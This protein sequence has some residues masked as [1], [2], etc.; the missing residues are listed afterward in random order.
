MLNMLKNH[1]IIVSDE[2][3][4]DVAEILF[5]SVTVCPGLNLNL[6]NITFDYERIVDDLENGKIQIRNLT[7]AQQVEIHTEFVSQKLI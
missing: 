5:P 1:I 7:E 6:K 4:I 2:S 3:L